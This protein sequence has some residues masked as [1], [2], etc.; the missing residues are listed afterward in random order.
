MIPTSD[1]IILIGTQTLMKTGYE[2][3]IL[4]LTNIVVRKVKQVEG[5]DVI[6]SDISYNP[7]KITDL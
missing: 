2:I 1:L 4:P 6:D 3:I 5:V 7:L